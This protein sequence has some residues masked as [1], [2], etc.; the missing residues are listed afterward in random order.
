MLLLSVQVCAHM[1]VCMEGVL[2]KELPAFSLPHGSNKLLFS[3][4]GSPFLI[5][6]CFSLSSPGGEQ[7][8]PLLLDKER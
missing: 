4:R 3:F 6:C 1:H 5:P 8:S 7:S 2:G